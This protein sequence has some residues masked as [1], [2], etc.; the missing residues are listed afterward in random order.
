M[1]DASRLYLRTLQ[2]ERVSKM[3]FA[4]THDLIVLEILLGVLSNCQPR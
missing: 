3:I 1:N 2:I 4:V